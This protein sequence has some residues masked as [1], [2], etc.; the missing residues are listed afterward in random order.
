MKRLGRSHLPALLL[1]GVLVAGVG[2]AAKPEPV[3]MPSPPPETFSSTGEAPLEQRW[4]TTFRDPALNRLMDRALTGNFDLESAWQRLRQARALIERE[5]SDLYPDLDGL[6]EAGARQPEPG[7]PER[8]ALGLAAEY[9]VDLWGRIRSRVEAQRLRARASLNDYRAAALSLSAEVARTWYE[10]VE[11]RSQR[12][13]LDEQVETNEKV[14]RALRARFGTGQIRAVDILRQEQ[15]VEA[16]RERLLAA[17]SRVQVVEHRLAVLVGQPPQQGVEAMRADL[18]DLPPLPKTGLPAE[19]VRRRPDVQRAY[20]L[21]LAADREL[22]AAISNR[23]PRLSLTASLTT[24]GED[25]GDLFDDWARSIAGNL[26]AP[27]IDGGE[28]R[29]EVDRAEALRSERLSDYAQATLTA[30]RE[31]EDALI[32]ERKQLD[33][34]ASLRQQVELASRTYEQLQIE[35][36]NG[37]ADYIDVLTALTDQQQLR[38]DLLAARLDLLDF[39]IGLYRALAGGFQTDRET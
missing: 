28:R 2:C 30:F 9:E 31:V 15:L 7:E 24:A 10:L 34:I 39:R 11:A 6:V 36:F 4:W 35:Y 26:V 13:L 19:L 38:R 3:S 8:V 18:P 27:L 21:L 5:S 32:Q 20:D 22:A 17:E 33:R 29:A 14:L 25:A 37:L 12:D 16:T 1:G 23:Y